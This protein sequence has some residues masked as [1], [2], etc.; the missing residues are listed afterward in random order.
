MRLIQYSLRTVFIIVALI[1][2]LV[3]LA[4]AVWSEGAR[5][6]TIVDSITAAKGQVFYWGAGPF[7]AES[8]RTSTWK[9][10]LAHIFGDRRF[11]EVCAIIFD[12]NVTADSIQLAGKLTSVRGIT[13]SG[14]QVTTDIAQRLAEVDHLTN[15]SLAECS[16][17]AQAILDLSRSNHI[18]VLVIT[19]SKLGSPTTMAICQMKSLRELDLSFSTIDADAWTSF[20][21]NVPLRSLRLVNTNADDIA[22]KQI[23]KI[24]T[25]R[26][27]NV[28]DTSISYDGLL[29]LRALPSLQWLCVSR[30]GLND[31]DKSRLHSQMPNCKIVE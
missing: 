10:P 16:F 25:L 18:E 22:A 4:C 23:A 1:G 13:L 28:S 5:Q 30:L 29:L 27:L 7:E 9:R 31:E 6:A 17:N 15:L 8:A 26:S 19:A 12:S 24:R 3:A 2:G 11:G 21:N 14:V 20:A